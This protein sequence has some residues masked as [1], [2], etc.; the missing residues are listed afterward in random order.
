MSVPTGAGSPS[1][2]PRAHASQPRPRHHHARA[3]RSRGVRPRRTTTPPSRSW[4]PRRGRLGHRR[5]G[6][7]V[8]RLPR[9]LLR[10]STSATPHPA[11]LPAARDQLDR[12]TL[13]SRAFHH[14][15]LG[16]F[17]RDLGPSW[18]AMDLV[19]PMNTG[20][21][22]VETA[23]KAGPPVG[24]RGQGRPDGRA[25]S[26]SPAGNFHGRT[27]TVVGFSTDPEARDRL[28]P[29]HPRLPHRP[30]RRRRGAARPRSP[31][32]PS[33]C[34][35]SRC[36]ARPGWSCRRRLP[37]AAARAC[38][39][40]PGVLLV[41]DE[42]QSGLGRTG[43]T[44]ACEPRGRDARRLR[45]RQGPRRRM[46]RSRRCRPPRRPGRHHPRQ[47]RLHVRRQRARLP[48]SGPRSSAAGDRRVTRPRARVLGA[49]LHGRL[50]RWSAP[51]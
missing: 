30:V 3:R 7:P 25:P 42:I 45:A 11:L 18:P 24:V 9:R 6:P 41:A 50:R 21:E 8:P 31:R 46:V 20:A 16:P 43:T 33:R 17:C 12:V 32:T 38:A 29:V 40:R 47:P 22:A 51:A 27:T 19:L 13:T 35:S 2:G 14:D 4:S 15:R 10:A 37:A 48:P 28:R 5:R 36:R 1:S 49:R 23:I 44:F 26:S 34:C 39:R